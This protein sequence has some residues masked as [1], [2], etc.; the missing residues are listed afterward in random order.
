MC[1]VRINR[2]LP[3]AVGRQAAARIRGLGALPLLLLRTHA[4]REIE[5]LGLAFDRVA[6]FG[7]WRPLKCCAVLPAKGGKPIRGAF[8]ASPNDSPNST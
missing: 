2:D 3:R 5:W 4:S 1:D 8:A 7:V 6:G